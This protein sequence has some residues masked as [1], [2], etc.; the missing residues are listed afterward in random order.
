MK[1]KVNNDQ[2]QD[3]PVTEQVKDFKEKELEEKEPEKVV[4]RNDVLPYRFRKF[5]FNY[6]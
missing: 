5:F 1:I 4:K 2:K 3:K 6:K